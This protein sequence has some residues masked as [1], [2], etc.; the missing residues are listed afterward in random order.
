MPQV[1]SQE[2]PVNPARAS[3]LPYK[4]GSREYAGTKV[5]L[6]SRLLTAV[7]IISILLFVSSLGFYIS[8]G[9]GLGFLV[10]SGV[11]A[12]TLNRWW[13]YL[14]VLFLTGTYLILV[15]FYLKLV[16]DYFA[17]NPVYWAS[18]L[19]LSLILIIGHVGYRTLQE[20]K[21]FLGRW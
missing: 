19:L 4:G 14:L 8:Q 11:F 7:K 5:Y 15:G 9:E 16:Y 2:I 21:A 20:W 13:L 12:M 6:W 10:L 18:L 17:D 3:E 1:Q